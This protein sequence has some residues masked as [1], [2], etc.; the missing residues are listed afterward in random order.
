MEKLTIYPVLGK[1]K[2]NNFFEIRNNYLTSYLHSYI[3]THY[4]NIFDKENKNLSV[5]WMSNRQY[6]KI[7]DNN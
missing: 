1:Y 2:V 6:L 3:P 7:I 4:F 5:E